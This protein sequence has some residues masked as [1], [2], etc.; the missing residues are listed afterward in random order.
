MSDVVSVRPDHR[1]LFNVASE[2]HGY[3]TVEQAHAC[4]FGWRA[5]LHHAKRGRFI[6]V[7]RELYRLRDYPS[8]P[9]EEVVAAWLAVGKDEAVVSHESALDLLEL[10]DVTPDSVHLTVPRGRRG[11]TP[12]PGTTVHTTSRPLPAADVVTLDGVRVTDAARSIVDV[13]ETG[14]GPEQIELA[15]FQALARGLTTPVHL[16]EQA[17]SRSRRVAEVVE[18][19]MKQWRAR[20]KGPS[21]ASA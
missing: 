2:Q 3:F 8:W 16:C 20:A 9:R 11:L 14:V 15:V 5:L 10:S 4:G 19:S 21:K 6:H 18:R 7:R 17:S 13:A 1:C 12:P